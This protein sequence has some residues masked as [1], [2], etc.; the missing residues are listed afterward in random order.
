[1]DSRRQ[2]PSQLNLEGPEGLPVGFKKSFIL[3]AFNFPCVKIKAS[4]L[5]PHFLFWAWAGSGS[6]SA[7]LTTCPGS[8]KCLS[9]VTP[10]LGPWALDGEGKGLVTVAG[11]VYP[12][13]MASN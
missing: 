13:G 2:S 1:M 10:P 3:A 7:G 5:E 9:G 12:S 6:L 11:K 4:G 8:L